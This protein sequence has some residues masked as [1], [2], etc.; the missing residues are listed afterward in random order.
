MK[1]V[2]YNGDLEVI[3]PTIG[4]TVEPGDVIDV[5]DDFEN[6]KFTPVDDTNNTKGDNQ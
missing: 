6:G 4:I 3:M 1:K 2:K 5:E